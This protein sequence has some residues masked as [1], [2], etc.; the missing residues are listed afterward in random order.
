VESLAAGRDA[1]AGW[2]NRVVA[3]QFRNSAEWLEAFLLCQAAGAIALPLDPDIPPEGV[4]RICACVRPVVLWDASGRQPLPDSRD[5]RPACLIKL[6]SGSTGTP[7]ALVFEDA[8]MI[9]DGR[10]IIRTMGLRP[11]DRQFV[12]IPLGHSYGLGN[13]VMP[14]LLQGCTLC[15]GGQPFPHDLA[16]CIAQTRASVFPAV[17]PLLN[18]LVRAEIDPALLRSLRLVISAGSPLDPRDAQAFHAR[19]GIQIHNFYGS[20]ETG[21]IAYDATG[22]HTLSGAAVGRPLAGVRVAAHPSG[23]LWV[24]SPAVYRRANRRHDGA[25]GAFLLPDQVAVRPDGALRLLGRRARLIK[26]GGKRLNPA[27]IERAITALD[28]VEAAFVAPFQDSSGRARLA[29]AV[30]SRRSDAELKAGL[31]AT[32]PRWKRPARWI[33]LDALPLTSRGKTDA[34]RLRD[35]L[36]RAVRPPDRS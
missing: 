9:A 35:L 36:Q 31:E 25:M 19:F 1:P 34:A 30:V 28:G 4:R 24:A 5:R 21:G 7:R 3:F 26:I 13:L 32:L 6:T 33:L 12:V 16:G 11:G 27:E 2:R 17:P 23:R 14:L 20:S 15:L 22:A 29:A 10:Q 8:Q 18:A